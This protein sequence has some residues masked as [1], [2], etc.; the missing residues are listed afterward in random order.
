MAITSSTNEKWSKALNLVFTLFGYLFILALIT[1]VNEQTFQY[2]YSQKVQAMLHD[3][4]FTGFSFLAQVAI[5]S[6]FL[7]VFTIIQAIKL[8][9]QRGRNWQTISVSIAYGLIAILA[10]VMTA[11]FQAQ[12]RLIEDDILNL[13]KEFNTAY[14]VL[15][16]FDLISEY[17]K[18][19]SN[20]SAAGPTE[21][22][23]TIS[24]LITAITG[25][26][27]AVS[28]FYAQVISARKANLEIEKVK[29]EQK[30]VVVEKKERKNT[31]KKTP[32]SRK[33]GK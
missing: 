29:L 22:V 21:Q 31:P 1:Q 14:S 33:K 19:L 3:R 11:S 15:S 25:L 2:F 20:P 8:T 23:A 24:T 5:V 18:E 28:G 7:I 10:V 12:F 32:S 27:A 26:I 9:L 16:R 17:Q 6:E 30:N 13:N 4:A